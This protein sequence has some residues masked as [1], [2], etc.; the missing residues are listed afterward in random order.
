MAEISGTPPV[1]DKQRKKPSGDAQGQL[2]QSISSLRMFS[3]KI[4]IKLL[5]KLNFVVWTGGWCAYW[6][7]GRRIIRP[8]SAADR[9]SNHKGSH[10]LNFS[11]KRIDTFNL[12]LFTFYLI[13]FLKF[14]SFKNSNFPKISLNGLTHLIWI[15]LLNF[16]LFFIYLLFIIYFLFF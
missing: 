8:L 6:T 7:R 12:N 9:R 3:M 16:Y 14:N 15:Y 5:S 10:R 2:C 4:F 13:Y 11:F 1:G